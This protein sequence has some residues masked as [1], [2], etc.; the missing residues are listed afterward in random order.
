VEWDAV[1]I[2][3]YFMENWYETEYFKFVSF[4]Y[5]AFLY[6][7]DWQVVRAV[8]IAKDL[9]AFRDEAAA[10]SGDNR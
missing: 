8:C 3:D 5:R 1:F 9:L 6:V 10:V 7:H 2:C 4:I